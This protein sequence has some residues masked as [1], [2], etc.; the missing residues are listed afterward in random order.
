MKSGARIMRTFVDRI[1]RAAKLDVNLYEEVEADVEATRQALAVVVLGSVAAGIGA[2]RG[3]PGGLLIG[4][5]AAL[6][7]WVV[8]AY[9]IYWIGTRLFP[10]PQTRAT[11]GE[12]L[13]TIG[14]ASSPGLLR[15]LGVVPALREIVFLLA[16]VWVLVTTVVAVR[17]A[18]D[19]R[20]TLRALGVCAVG[21]VVQLLL[22]ALALY[23]LR[24][25]AG[26]A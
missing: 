25:F 2:G 10:E 23:L 14:F 24:P 6:G 9:L 22:V 26:A 7:G 12:L 13:R 17:Q 19:Y 11:H 15:V 21:W 3:S 4:G 18:L 8:W 20:G 5:V 1:I 16:S